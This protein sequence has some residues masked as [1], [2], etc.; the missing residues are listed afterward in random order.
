MGTDRHE[1]DIKRK[2]RPS[3]DG[4]EGTNLRDAFAVNDIDEEN[5]T[6]EKYLDDNGEPGENVRTKHP[7]RNPDKGDQN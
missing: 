1:N 6:A 2:G 3:G 4:K 5:K 7:N